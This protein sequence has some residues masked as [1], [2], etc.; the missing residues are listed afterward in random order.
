MDR[1]QKVLV[2]LGTRPEAIKLAPVIRALRACPSDFAVTVCSTGQHNEM[3]RQTLRTLSIVPDID[4]ASMRPSQD[5]NGLLARVVEGVGA[6]LAQTTPDLVVVQGDTTTALATTLAAFHEKIPVAHVEAG[7]RTHDLA[8]PF[9]EEMNRTLVGQLAT[10]HFAPT[11]GNRENLL[12]EGLDPNVVIVTGNTAVDSLIWMASEL[13]THET[14]RDSAVAGI[15][16]ALPFAWREHPFVLVTGHR[17]ENFSGGLRN[18]CGALLE[19]AREHPEMHFVYP[20]HM[21]PHVQE[22]AREML[23][24]H[25]RI[26]LC[27]PV[28]YAQMIL[29]L[30]ACYF[31]ISDSGGVQ[32]EAAT[33]HKPLLLTR[34]S[35]ERTEGVVSGCAKVVGTSLTTLV[36]SALRL[37]ANPSEH[38]E[39][40]RAPNPYGDGLASMRIR[41]FLTAL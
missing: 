23:S 18:M 3:L 27:S 9:P 8:S 35:S 30:E 33:L 10:W 2:T 1:P 29:L 16:Q 4:L 20:V 40:S 19:I 6:L 36:E 22:T 11:L 34:T 7:L 32:E 13:R 39:M 28:D 12:R 31:V 21:N 38:E 17:R 14:L 37:L 26:H 41:D 5:L 25:D 15:D 24:D